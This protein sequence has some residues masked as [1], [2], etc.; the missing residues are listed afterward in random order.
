[1][2]ANEGPM[3]TETESAKGSD[4]DRELARDV[5]ARLIARDW[6]VGIAESLTGGLVMS[7]LV[8][9]P[10]ASR[11]V[12]GGILAY[13]TDLKSSVL[14]VDEQLLATHG[15]VHPEV[16]RQMAEGARHVTGEGSWPVEVGISTTGVAGP[17]PQDGQA[18]GTVYVCV[19]TPLGAQTDKLR[20]EGSRADIRGE[21]TR[22]VLMLAQSMV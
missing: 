11:C 6:R 2:R 3:V 17:E 14:G 20:L 21:S 7:A 5:C 22:R 13:A 8:A 16:A 1:M 19:V 12:R 18:V 4:A 10:G 15:A 9:V